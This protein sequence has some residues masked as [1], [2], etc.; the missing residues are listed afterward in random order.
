MGTRGPVPKGYSSRARD[1]L[2][3]N[4]Q[5]VV[6]LDGETRGFDLPQPYD[7][8]PATKNWWDHWRVSPIAQLWEVAD[9]DFAL[10]TAALHTRFWYRPTALN[11]AELRQRE[12][13]MGQTYDD[14]RRLH[15][16]I[17]D[18]DNVEMKG[19]ASSIARLN[20]YRGTIASPKA[21]GN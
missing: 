3:R 13:K 6:V 14:R 11:A 12:A 18:A 5:T 20:D 21:E 9:W 4:P 8:H 15:V 19:P 7:W 10:V 16:Q 2:R 17:M 1:E